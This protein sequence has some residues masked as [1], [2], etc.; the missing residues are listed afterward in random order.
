MKLSQLKRTADQLG[1]EYGDMFTPK[2]LDEW[3][4]EKKAWVR[5][6]AIE[7]DGEEVVGC[8]IHQKGQRIGLCCIVPVDCVLDL[9]GMYID[10]F[11]SM[12]AD[13]FNRMKIPAKTVRLG[14]DGPWT[15]W[16]TRFIMNP[17]NRF[18]VKIKNKNPLDLRRANLELHDNERFSPP[19]PY[20]A[21]FEGKRGPSGQFRLT[22]VVE[23]GH[24]NPQY[25][26]TP[27][28]RTS[29]HR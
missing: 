14:K 7:I 26:F 5:Q 21:R 19:I 28:G 29:R 1:V 4:E 8:W 17:S 18:S 15:L 11:F 20:R 13:T 3:L 25:I 22:G 24:I 27:L 9:V 16:S 2:A 12:Y 6:Q 23:R 10:P